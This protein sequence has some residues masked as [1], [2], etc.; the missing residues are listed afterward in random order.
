MNRKFTADCQPLLI[1]SLPVSDHEQAA[2]LV[3]TYAS[4]VPLWVQLPVFEQEGM[5]P[6]FA[7]GMPGLKHTGE[8]WYVDTEDP[9]FPDEITAFYEAYLSVSAE[10]DTIEA[11]RFALSAGEAQ[12][13]FTFLQRLAL[14]DNP[15]AAVKGQVTGPITFCTGLADQD[16]RAIFYNDDLRDAAVKHLAAKA[17]WQVRKLSVARCPVIIFLD[18]PAL[19]GFGSSE[20][21]SI[22]R[23]DVAACLKECID[24]VHMAGGLVGVHV[25][26][27]TDW[28]LLLESEVDIINFDAYAYFDRFVLYPDHI[29]SYLDSGR[30]LAWGIVP[31]LN[32]ADIERENVDSLVEKLAHHFKALADLGIDPAQLRRQSLVT[33]SCGTGSLSIALA[34]RVLE[35][36]RGV[37]RRLRKL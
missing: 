7:L 13:F 20:F 12:G 18:E 14:Y 26:A 11:S 34:T 35:L 36:T 10:P 15:P 24:A 8:R 17:Q 5:I 4:P 21:T 19:A 22:T 28:T 25:C 27:N 3:E 1:G 32:A 16:R 9:A 33:P 6:Q 31:T 37:S 2:D 30:M 29:R 23:E